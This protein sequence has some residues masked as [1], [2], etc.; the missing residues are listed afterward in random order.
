MEVK[1]FASR[2]IELK[3]I[4][5]FMHVRPDGDCVGSALG[6][7][8]ALK[9]LGKTVAVFSEDEI[10]EKFS[11]LN[12]ISE[13]KSVFEGEFDGYISVD[14]TDWSRTGGFGEVFNTK[15][16]TFNFDHHIS[17]TYFAKYNVMIDSAS[18][19]EIVLD[20][21][22]ELGVEIDQDIAMALA[23]GIITDTGNFKHSNVEESTFYKAGR[24]KKHGADFNKITYANF[25][26]QSKNRAKL[27]AETMSKIRYLLDDKLAIVVVT[28]EMIKR[29]GA[30]P[31]ETEGFVDF[32]LGIKE[33]EVAVCIMQTDGYYKASFRAKTASVNAVAE[34]FG[35]GGHVLAAGCRYNG[36]VEEF[37]DKI[38]YYVSQNLPE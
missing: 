4:A 38:R 8:Y 24:L 19:S 5:I 27:F 17:N 1:A 14:C 13:I 37:I 26:A 30:K 9:K 31:A 6:L 15:K 36:E 25:T 32:I 10:P 12:G 22:D 34:K 35:G 33:V 2:L 28:E 16:P 21:I 3:S 11:Y 20:L 7:Y 29:S 18:C 23:T